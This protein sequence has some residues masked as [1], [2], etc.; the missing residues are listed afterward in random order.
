[1]HLPMNKL[2]LS[3]LIGLAIPSLGYSQDLIVNDEK[4]SII[5]RIKKMDEHF[6]YFTTLERGVKT[7]YAIDRSTVITYRKGYYSLA[8]TD[9]SYVTKRDF[10][11]FSFGV[12]IGY[13]IRLGGLPDGFDSQMK[14]HISKLRTGFVYELNPS[15]YFSENSGLGIHIIGF[16][17]SATTATDIGQM[18][19]KI[20]ITYIGPSWDTK[21]VSVDGKGVLK[22]NLGLGYLGYLDNASLNG[23]MTIS[24]GSI[25]LLTYLGYDFLGENQKS[26]L[27]LGLRMILGSI[28]KVKISSGYNSSTTIDLDEPEN[29]SHIDLV[30]GFR[31]YN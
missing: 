9:P 14:S 8:A 31:L 10:S 30:I 7:S 2:F 17:K 12:N 24:G 26:G 22:A 3:V 27:S 11:S 1:M 18:T 21:M 4:D 19:D 20:R 6:I 16:R 15:F 23:S 29:L 13:G 25:G 5:C 28:G